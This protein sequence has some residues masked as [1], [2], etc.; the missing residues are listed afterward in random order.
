M[1]D[2]DSQHLVEE[3]LQL[4]S[5]MEVEERR[6][7]AKFRTNF[8]QMQSDSDSWLRDCYSLLNGDDDEK[9]K[10][11]EITDDLLFEVLERSDES[12]ANDQR[13][14]MLTNAITNVTYNF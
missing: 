11:D 14:V 7:E 6:R 13:V 4:W 10:V 8:R 3:G 12:M 1:Q 2:L 5:A 9:A